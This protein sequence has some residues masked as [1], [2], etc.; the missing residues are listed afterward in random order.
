MEPASCAWSCTT[1]A[2]AFYTAITA[3]T[4]IS[5]LPGESWSETNLLSVLFYKFFLLYQGFPNQTP[6]PQSPSSLVSPTSSHPPPH[7]NHPQR[8]QV[9]QPPLSANPMLC[10]PPPLPPLPQPQPSQQ[11]LS[12]GHSLPTP[13]AGLPPPPPPSSLGPHQNGPPMTMGPYNPGGAPMPPHMMHHPPHPMHPGGP[14]G[15][16]GPPPPNHMQG[17]PGPMGPHGG[18]GGPMFRRHGPPP[19]SFYDMRQPEFR[20]Y[21]MNRRLQQRGDESDNLWWDAFANEFFEDDATLTITFCLEDGPKRYSEYCS[22]QSHIFIFCLIILLIFT[23][24]GRTLI[25]RYF[26]SIFEGGVTDMQ[27]V[28]KFPKESLHSPTVT[29][30]SEQTTIHTQHGKPNFKV[31]SFVI[32]VFMFDFYNLLLSLDRSISTERSNEGANH[33]RKYRFCC[34]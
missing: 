22:L 27:I 4:G 8:G 24:I 23:A 13:P 17:P 10:G 16:P 34:N 30:D 18:P 20:I 9:S 31:C 11:P 32:F 19:P 5:L 7:L 14:P 25:P 3:P 12:Q 26:R 1:A 15:P 33:Q 29:L 2:A 21:E 6:P 28:M